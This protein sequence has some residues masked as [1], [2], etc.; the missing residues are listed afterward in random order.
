MAKDRGYAWIV[1]MASFFIYIICDGIG[2]SFGVFVPYIKKNLGTTTSQAGFIGSLHIGLCYLT[3]PFN[4]ALA[5]TFGYRKMSVV[6]AIVVTGALFAA[7]QTSTL[8]S[9]T[10]AYGLFAS[11]GICMIITTAELA[12]NEYFDAKRSLANGIVFSGSSVGYFVSAPILTYILEEHGLQTGFIVEG[13]V[14]ALCILLGFLLKTYEGNEELVTSKASLG[15]RLKVSMYDMMERD[16]LFDK[17][18]LLYSVGRVFN[19]LPLIVPLI[20]MPSMLSESGN[21]I[22]QME[23][24]LSITIIGICNLC[25]RLM[26]GLL[27]KCP[28]F[29][30]KAGF[31]LLTHNF[32]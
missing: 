18:F 22:S 3:A 19:Y 11:L 12:T 21:G 26:C 13:S 8:L 7:G 2:M 30:I 27:D 14:T 24:G 4:I 10:L 23:A 17:G 1:C 5:K 20:Y 25:G 9:I 6:G 31:F 16:V 15:D 32:K 28:N 29:V